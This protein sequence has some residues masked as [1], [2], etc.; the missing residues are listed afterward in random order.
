MRRIFAVV[1][2]V[3]FVVSLAT[4][5]GLAAQPILAP[6]ASG[7]VDRTNRTDRLKPPAVEYRVVGECRSA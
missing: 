1:I 5:L 3:L 2:I 4:V 7:V 6:T